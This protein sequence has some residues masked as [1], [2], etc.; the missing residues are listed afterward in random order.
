MRFD[1]DFIDELK[2]KWNRQVKK[3]KIGCLIL[4]TIM[5]VAGICCIIYPLETFNVMKIIISIV[6]IS[7]GIYHMI[8]YCMSSVYF[9]E[10]INIITGLIHILFGVLLIKMPPEITAMSLTLMLAILLLFSGAEKISFS[11][12]LSLFGLWDTSKYMYSGILN[13]VLAVVF[14]ILPISSVL[15][16]NYI[17]A[18]YM[19]VH[20]ISLLIEALAMKKL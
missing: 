13:I 12:R 19:I 5:I 2:E 7:F 1:L 20:G 14:I 11:R 16:I 3:V 6:F 18:A 4:S 15:V 10:P 17:I 9:K 8:A